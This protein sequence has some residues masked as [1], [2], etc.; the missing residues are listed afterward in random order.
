MAKQVEM[1]AITHSST[2]NFGY[3]KAFKAS[4]PFYGF[5]RWGKLEQLIPL[6]RETIR[7]LEKAGQFPRRVHLTP[8]TAAWPNSELHIW[9]NDPGAYRAPVSDADPAKDLIALEKRS[10][11]LARLHVADEAKRAKAKSVEQKAERSTIKPVSRP[12]RA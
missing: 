12:T 7:K 3:A 2:G 11:R 8:G 10:H 5:T 9:R 4:L 6:A 1:S